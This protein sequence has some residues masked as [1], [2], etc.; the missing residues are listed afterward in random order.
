MVIFALAPMRPLRLAD[1]DGFAMVNVESDDYLI[2]TLLLLFYSLH[3]SR[4][5]SPVECTVGHISESLYSFRAT[6]T[7][8]S[9][10]S[11][12]RITPC[13]NCWAIINLKNR[14]HAGKS[15]VSRIM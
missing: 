12:A 7:C 3:Y 11:S 15:Q 4:T 13:Y 1:W 5:D 2:L 14:S 9:F 8:S 6:N 10:L